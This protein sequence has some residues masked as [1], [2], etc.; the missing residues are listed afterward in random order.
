MLSCLSLGEIKLYHFYKHF[1]DIILYMNY[2]LA[3]LMQMFA[4]FYN[5]FK[6]YFTFRF[7]FF[8]I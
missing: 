6:R 4:D 5:Y 1:P 7:Y 3:I 8:T 2:L